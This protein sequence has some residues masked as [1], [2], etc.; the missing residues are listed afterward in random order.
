MKHF[1]VLV[2]VLVLTLGK[3]FAGGWTISGDI[4]VAQGGTDMSILNSQISE[5]GLDVTANSSDD[6]RI[7]WQVL[8]SY[9]YTPEFG[10]EIGYV[11]LG[12][13]SATLQGATAEIDTFLTTVSDIHPLTAIGWQL[14]ASYR[15]PVDST[16]SIKLRAGILDWRSKYKLETTG[17]SHTVTG[18]GSSGVFAAGI[19]KSIGQN[20]NLNFTY[21]RYDIDRESVSILGVG[22]TYRVD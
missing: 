4:G 1:T 10:V 20:R 19:E 16:L 8:L 6:N 22:L 15:I 14:S 12:E 2:V 13:V 21:S 7:A 18:S 11:D 17:A 5:E 9:Q 3:A